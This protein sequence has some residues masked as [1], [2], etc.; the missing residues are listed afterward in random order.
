M[1]LRYLEN[2]TFLHEQLTAGKS[3][4]YDF[5]YSI[6]NEHVLLTQT[7]LQSANLTHHNGTRLIPS[8]YLYLKS[9]VAVFYVT[10]QKA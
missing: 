10:I 1:F 7:V 9:I 4:L 3:V 5:V 2:I 8:P 6:H